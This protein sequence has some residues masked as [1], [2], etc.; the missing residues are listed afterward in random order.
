MLK[1][2]TLSLMALCCSAIICIAD[3]TTEQTSPNKPIQIERGKTGTIIPLDITQE[4]VLPV[5]WWRD[6]IIAI[7]FAESEGLAQIKITDIWDY[8]V[9]KILVRVC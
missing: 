3:S 9:S 6:G 8:T 4:D 7:E 2:V 1:R 5:A